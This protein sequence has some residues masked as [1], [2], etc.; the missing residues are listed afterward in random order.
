[1]PRIRTVKPEYFTHPSILALSIP[2]RLLFI[3]VWC[4]CDDEGRLYNHSGKI[5]ALSFGDED[6][7]RFSSLLAELQKPTYCDECATAHGHIA[8][9][10]AEGR[11]CI[12]VVHFH[13]HQRIDRPSRSSIPAPASLDEDSS[14]TRRTLDEP[15]ANMSVRPNIGSR[16]Q[17]NRERNPHASRASDADRLAEKA[18]LDRALA[19]ALYIDP[20]DPT[21]PREGAA[22]A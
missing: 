4:Q 21:L 17:G 9:Y 10:E 18:A 8:L 12:Q 13:R 22:D 15:S 6:K 19:S 1:M 3:S 5:R 14:N 11:K 2:A 16:D 7:V 20:I